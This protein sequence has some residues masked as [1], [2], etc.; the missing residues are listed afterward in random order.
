MASFL[1]RYLSIFLALLALCYLSPGHAAE[2]VMTY[3]YWDWGITPERDN[4]QV[5]LLTLALEKTRA[6]DGEYKLERIQQR[7]ST[8]RAHRAI[9]EGEQLNIHASPFQASAAESKGRL[10]VQVPIMNSLLGYRRLIIRRT[11]LDK[12]SHINTPA[13]LQK[14]VAGQGHDWADVSIYRHNG[15]KVRDNAEYFTLFSMLQAGRFDYIP[16]S[17]IEA[18]NALTQYQHLSNELMIVPDLMLYYPLP[19]FFYVSDRLPQFAA[20]LEKGLQL[21]RDDGSLNALFKEHFANYLQ[22]MNSRN[23]RILV[24]ENPS[25]GEEMGLT[26]PLLIAPEAPVPAASSAPVSLP[27]S[28]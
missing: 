16:L 11:D 10:A 14:L 23:L 18:D 1:M 12:F 22:Q 13:Q 9:A 5:A 28:H 24:L 6:S 19:T 8:A 20:R 17:I 26:N 7:L 27:D 4:Y 3:R 25:V 21:S 2:K 15:Y